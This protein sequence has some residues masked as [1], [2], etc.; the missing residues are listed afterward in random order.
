[1]KKTF[2]FNLI[3]DAIDDVFVRPTCASEYKTYLL[4]CKRVH[5]LLESR[6][7]AYLTEFSCNATN[8]V[9]M[10]YCH[11]D[12]F[13][14]D[15]LSKVSSIQWRHVKLEKRD[16]NMKALCRSRH[17]DMSVVRANPH[18]DWDYKSLVMNSNITPD[19]FPVMRSHHVCL[20]KNPNV[21]KEYYLA[22]PEYRWHMYEIYVKDW[23]TSD[24]IDVDEDWV[25][26]RYTMNPSLTIEFVLDNMHKDWDWN[27]IVQSEMVTLDIARK[28]IAANKCDF[29]YLSDN[30]HLTQEFIE[31]FIEMPWDWPTLSMHE[32]V[33]INFVIRHS[34]REW[35]WRVLTTY[36]ANMT[37]NI[38]ADNFDLPWDLD[39]LQEDRS[40]P[41]D[42][43]ARI[44][45]DKLRWH[46]L[47]WA[48][49]PQCEYPDNVV[50]LR[51]SVIAPIKDIL[52]GTPSEWDI[53]CQRSDITFEFIA[54][55]KNVPWDFHALSRRDG[56]PWWLVAEYPDAPWH[57]DLITHH[58]R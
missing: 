6:R 2:D 40:I 11:A 23:F 56:L 9:V 14:W 38:I 28:I 33:T 45:K 46:N 34:E 35:D 42:I 13:R 17:I 37:W 51:K 30:P 22:H 53:I 55:H 1:M 19:D 54:K 52:D 47:I 16:Y 39:Q 26:Y 5:R 36:N 4:V 8:M 58:L 57:F 41:A 31:E 21:T 32:C 18:V 49:D 12:K 44:P 10:N 27:M 15:S 3:I 7:F 25:Y 29:A 50:N 24:M 20:S 48:A 43:I